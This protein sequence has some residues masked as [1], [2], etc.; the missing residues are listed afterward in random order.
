MCQPIGLATGIATH[1][2]HSNMASLRFRSNDAPAF[3]LENLGESDSECDGSN[4]SGF[5]SVDHLVYVEENTDSHW[6][7][8]DEDERAVGDVSQWSR[9][10]ADD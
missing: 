8:D 3:F 9:V 5:Q 2:N 10:V 6:I 4:F 7:S 1:G